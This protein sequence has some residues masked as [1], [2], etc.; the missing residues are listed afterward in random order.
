[1]RLRLALAVIL[2]ISAV[3]QTANRRPSTPPPA[4]PRTVDGSTASSSPE[5]AEQTFKVDVKLV[6]VIATVKDKHGEPVGDLEKSDIRLTDNGAPQEIT[7]F[8]KHTAQPLYVAILLDIS[9]STAKEMK[10]QTAAVGRFVSALFREGNPDDRA[11]LWTFNWQIG[12]DVPWTRSP[13]RFNETMKHLK[14]EAGTALYDAIWMASH[15][16]ADREGR[17]VMIVVSDGGNTFSKKDFHA[18]RE[19]AHAAD[20]V[21]YP[22]LTMPITNMAGR[23]IGGENALT[24]FAQ[25]TGGKVFAPGIQGIDRA[26]ADILHD[27][28]TQ[29][30]IGYYPRKVPLSKNR[31]HQLDLKTVNPDL[32]V[33]SR[34]GYYGDAEPSSDSSRR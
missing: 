13:G 12:N 11:S 16:L 6:R 30:L 33:V 17:H 18:A 25:E 34:T 10:G 14:A 29:Y 15:D 20:A 1:M 28:R 22:V 9:G 19:A 32:H 3:A 2:A 7:L 31:F 27:L 4:K 5:A 21:I 26:F 24:T 23:N 8:E